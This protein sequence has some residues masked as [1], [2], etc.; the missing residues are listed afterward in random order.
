MATHGGWSLEV[1]IKSLLVRILDGSIEGVVLGV[2]S[3]LL[4]L[5]WEQKVLWEL[6]H[7]VHVGF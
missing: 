4:V 1:L 2:E 6:I 3:R 5:V 7:S